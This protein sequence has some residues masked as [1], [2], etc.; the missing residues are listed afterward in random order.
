V[1]TFRCLRASVLGSL[2]FVA[3]ISNA[4]AQMTAG[5]TDAQ[6]QS[7]ATAEPAQAPQEGA[8]G[9]STEQSGATSGGIA[10]GQSGWSGGTGPAVASEPGELAPGQRL[11]TIAELSADYRDNAFYQPTDGDRRSA[12][13]FYFRPTVIYSNAAPQFRFVGGGSADI[14]LFTLPGT[15]DDYQDF[16][17]NAGMKWKPSELHVLGYDIIVARGHDPYG[18]ARTEGTSLASRS[19]DKWVNESYG[20]TY[21][22][23]APGLPISVEVGGAVSRRAYKTNRSD[24]DPTTHVLTGGTRFLDRDVESGQVLFLYHYSPKTSAL[25]DFAARQINFDES[26]PGTT[27]QPAHPSRNGQEYHVRAGFK[28]LATAKTS[29]DARVG[30]MTRRFQSPQLNAYNAFDWQVNLNWT[31][32]SYL[33]FELQTGRNELEGYDNAT[34]FIDVRYVNLFMKQQWSPRLK[35]RIGVGYS[36]ASFYPSARHDNAENASF[37]AEYRMLRYLSLFGGYNYDRRG[38][39]FQ[40]TEYYQNR[41]YAGLRLDY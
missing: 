25:I 13:G 35:S 16:S 5:D 19:L 30:Y 40:F 33:A 14:A 6:A 20:L 9:T 39:T 22:Y 8:S 18:L 1:H 10:A 27:G 32:L 36:N 41:V 38:S 26:F 29:G 31:P 11:H 34:G 28:W 7:E 12:E 2:I 24:F 37:E 15:V 4:W 21:A 23:G 17:A 3:G